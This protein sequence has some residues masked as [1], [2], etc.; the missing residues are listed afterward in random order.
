MSALCCCTADPCA[1]F[2]A[3]ICL[4]NSDCDNP[5]V[6]LNPGGCWACATHAPA[7]PGPWT[8]VGPV[9]CRSDGE[10]LCDGM[11][12]VLRDKLNVGPVGHFQGVMVGGGVAQ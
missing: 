6:L 11:W 4:D 9:A 3:P 5:A 7:R 12:V 1:S 8:L 2:A 10:P